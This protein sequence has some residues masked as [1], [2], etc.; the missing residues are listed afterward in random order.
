MLSEFPDNGWTAGIIDSLLKRIHKTA[1]QAAVDH[2]C[3]IAVCSVRC[4]NQ[5]GTDQLMRFRM[6][7]LFTTQV[8]TV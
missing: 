3:R 5:E 1:D 7:L 2:I 4:K 6:K 8:C